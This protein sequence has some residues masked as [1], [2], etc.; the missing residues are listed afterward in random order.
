MLAGLEIDEISTSPVVLPKVKKTIRSLKFV[1]AKKMAEQAL[2]F[3]TGDEVR[4]FITE[5]LREVAGDL[6]DD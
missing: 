2:Q 1:E 5:K 6:V 4:Q 3:S